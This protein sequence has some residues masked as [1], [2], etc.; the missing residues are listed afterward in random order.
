MSTSENEY[1]VTVALEELNSLEM[2]KKI[3]TILHVVL[4]VDHRIKNINY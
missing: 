3:V 2:K 1:F 4:P